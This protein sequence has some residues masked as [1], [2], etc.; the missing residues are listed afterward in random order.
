MFYSVLF[1]RIVY[2]ETDLS[3]DVLAAINDLTL[4]CNR[5]LMSSTKRHLILNT[6]AGRPTRR[7]VP[8]FG[9]SQLIVTNYL[10]DTKR[11]VFIGLIDAVSFT[12]NK[13]PVIPKLRYV[14]TLTRMYYH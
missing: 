1:Q 4:L 12:R 14:F 13:I 3:T 6:Q 5:W 11:N 2:I 10:R 9:L 8:S 7:S